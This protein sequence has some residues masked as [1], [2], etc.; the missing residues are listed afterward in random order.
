MNTNKSKSILQEHEVRFQVVTDNW[1][2]EVKDPAAAFDG[3]I[4]A[5]EQHEKMIKKLPP[6][7]FISKATTSIKVVMKKYRVI[8]EEEVVL[9]EHDF[10]DLIREYG[11]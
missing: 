10:S 8:E 9:V 1:S 6:E 4:R 5:K 11:Y 7:K 2:Y 3:L